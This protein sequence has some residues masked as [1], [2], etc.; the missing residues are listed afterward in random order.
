MTVIL[1]GS[2]SMDR[3][4]PLLEQQLGSLPLPPDEEAAILPEITAGL[5]DRRVQAALGTAPRLLTGWRMPPRQHPDHL[6]LRL[7]AQV[8][9]G[10]QS[11]RFQ[12]DLVRQMQARTVK[13]HYLAL[14]LGTVERD[15][16]V[17]APLGRH[18]VQRTKMAI[19]RAG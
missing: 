14:A 16:C 5:G 17:D 8:L 2:F 13:R 4:L 3:V 11:C 7:A 9:A 1:I 10:V 12:T 18:A 6:A 15:G 19:V